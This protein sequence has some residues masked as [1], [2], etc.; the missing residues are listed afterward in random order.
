M[1]INDIRIAILGGRGMLGTDLT[2]ICRRQ[3]L[4]VEVFDLQRQS[5]I[6]Q[7]ILMLMVPRM[8]QN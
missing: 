6:A 4:N 3:G 2:K 1:V 7:L 5:S 8:R